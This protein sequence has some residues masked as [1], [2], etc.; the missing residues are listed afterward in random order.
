MDTMKHDTKTI[1]TAGNGN[2]PVLTGKVK[3]FAEKL[4][5]KVLA[6]ITSGKLP[7][8]Q[9]P[10]DG[11][12]RKLFGFNAVSGRGY[13]GMNALAT[14]YVTNEKKFDAPAFLT[15]KQ[16]QE[17][18]GNVRKGE[19]GIQVLKYFVRDLFTKK[20]KA[21]SESAAVEA[22][23]AA[24]VSHRTLF[25]V[26]VY[27][28]FN[29]AQCDGIDTA[30]LKSLADFIKPI[31]AFEKNNRIEELIKKSGVPVY[32]RG[33]KGC[34]YF[35]PAE[36]AIC[37]PDHAFFKS[38]TD[39]YATIMHELS[40]AFVQKMEIDFGGYW[41][42]EGRAREETCVEMSAM[43]IC[44]ELGIAKPEADENHKAYAA[45]W[46]SVLEKDKTEA[47]R[48]WRTAMKIAG[49]ILKLAPAAE[50]ESAAA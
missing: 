31:P 13:N 30:K 1:E 19:H 46:I 14:L 39:Y 34:A 32:E 2:I 8:W 3:E 42:R 6:E 11:Y 16:A 35:S 33:N 41:T 47:A 28:V 7:P 20:E 23:A 10:F 27:T 18:G 15:Y 26:R 49:E 44:N 45:H 29:I 25:S 5:E 43:L 36:R 48:L 17:L 50:T 9:R 12:G 24:T 40:H 38:E 37:V 21:A 4:G 22:E